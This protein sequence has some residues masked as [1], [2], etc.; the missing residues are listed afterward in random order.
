MI[1]PRTLWKINS[2][3]FEILERLGP[4]LSPCLFVFLGRGRRDRRRVD[5]E[6]IC[7][8]FR[9]RHHEGSLLQM[10]RNETN[11]KQLCAH[12]PSPNC[13]SSC[14]VICFLICYCGTRPY[15][16]FWLSEKISLLEGGEF[17][18]CLTSRRWRCNLS[19]LEGV[20]SV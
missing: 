13:P 7:F 12:L 10:V 16:L 11:L 2:P 9:Y 20:V 19:C 4:S 5:S 8:V 15:L 3:V 1:A 17:R 6:G 14:Q 18:G